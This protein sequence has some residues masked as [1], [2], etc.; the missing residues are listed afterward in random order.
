MP[1]ANGPELRC[2]VISPGEGL[3]RVAVSQ[4]RVGD[5]PRYMCN[6]VHGVGP[7]QTLPEFGRKPAASCRFHHDPPEISALKTGSG[8][9]F[10]SR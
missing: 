9:P 5:A 7:G 2:L 6:D 10:D 4:A 1:R 3:D 8:V